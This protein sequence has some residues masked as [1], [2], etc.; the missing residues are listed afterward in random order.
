[1][2]QSMETVFAGIK[3]DEGSKKLALGWLLLAIMS[4]VFAGI[5]AFLLA[6]S[7][8]PGVQS[9]FSSGSFIYTALVVH[10][11]LA[12]VTWFLTFCGVLLSISFSA[13]RNTPMKAVPI[14]WLGLSLAAVG[15]VQLI[16]P[17]FLKGGDPSLN[18]YI[19]VLQSHIYYSGMIFFASGLFLTLLHSFYN[20]FSGK[21]KPMPEAVL[22][23]VSFGMGAFGIT[24]IIA[25]VCFGLAYN[26]L[27]P[28]M[29]P[30]SYFER[31]FWGGGHILQISNTIGMLCSWLLLARLTLGK[32]P[33]PDR[34]VKFFF[35][36]T[37]FFV[38][39][40]PM[41]YFKTNILSKEYKDA[42]TIIMEW[43]FSP[44]A[45]LIGVGILRS[46]LSRTKDAQ[47]SSWLEP[48]FSALVFSM[49]LFGCGG[50]IGVL[51]KG[52]DVRIPAH[53]HGVIGAVTM[54]FMGLSFYLL[55]LFGRKVHF[56]RMA[57]I[58]PYLYGIGQLMFMLGLFLAGS[59][60]VQRKTYGEAQNL[61]QYAKVVGMTIM[62]LGGFVAISGGITFLLNM[63]FSV[64]KTQGKGEAVRS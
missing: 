3:I 8:T 34:A 57:R 54:S 61:D 32:A 52:S 30:K 2:I 41:I 28:S 45:F 49:I 1:M 17:A 55:P 6:T 37:V 48:G 18:N 53:Y 7:R 31:L 38:L 9:L 46:I 42:F 15:T 60:G 21:G 26:A 4:L 64:F 13:F 25:F 14:G 5:F 27:P 20:A 33:I 58:Q 50:I 62:G 29:S 35:I 63:L 56:P 23:Q 19:P 22:S 16:L 47:N 40:A 59:H 43:C 51:I 11:V 36:I 24:V 12:I 44:A 39:P 10:V